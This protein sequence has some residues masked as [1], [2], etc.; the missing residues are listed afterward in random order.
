[1]LILDES[2]DCLDEQNRTKLW[3]AIVGTGIPTFIISHSQEI[4]S[5]IDTKISISKEKNQSQ[6]RFGIVPDNRSSNLNEIDILEITEETFSKTN[7]EEQ[8][9]SKETKES[10][11]LKEKEIVEANIEKNEYG[12]DEI[13]LTKTDKGWYYGETKK[14]VWCGVCNRTAASFQFL[15]GRKSHVAGVK[16]IGNLPK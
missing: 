13:Q 3:D 8:S 2:L 16:H 1:M 15:G 7:V 12:P 4:K 11:E 10:K 14:I 9:E 5:G 6:I